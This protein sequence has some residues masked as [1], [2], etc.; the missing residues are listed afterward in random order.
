MFPTLEFVS[1]SLYLFLICS[2]RLFS[3]LKPPEGGAEFRLKLVERQSAIDPNIRDDTAYFGLS[4]PGEGL[5]CLSLT[6]PALIV[7]K[8]N[9][10]GPP[11]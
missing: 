10:R 6:G 11:P 8:T 5:A 2:L 4:Q 1:Q 7:G 3:F 9:G